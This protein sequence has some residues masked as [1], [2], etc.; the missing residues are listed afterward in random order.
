MCSRAEFTPIKGVI[1]DMDGTLTKPVLNFSEM[2]KQLGMQPGGDIM[3]HI[4]SLSMSERA[5]ALQIVERIE[6]EANKKMELQPGTLE[7]L[8]FLASKSVSTQSIS[9]ILILQ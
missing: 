2:R 1:F 7:L 5:K 6:E 4:N 8:D 9:L 3:T